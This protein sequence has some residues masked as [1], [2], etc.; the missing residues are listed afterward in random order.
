MQLRVNE[1]FYSVQGEGRFTGT[2][3]V[4]LRLSGCNQKCDFCDTLHESFT[5]MTEEEIV[6]HVCKFAARHIVI[7]G[8]EP[9]LQLTTPFINKLHTVGFFV[10]IETN[11]SIALP[12]DCHIDWITCSPKAAPVCLAYVDELKVVYRGQDVSKWETFPAKEHRLQPMDTQNTN[13][14]QR[15]LQQ[16]MEYILTHPIWRL[17]LQTHKMIGVR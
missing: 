2:P 16:T 8:G 11:G 9:T 17:S 10:Q 13:E 14:N 3:A 5:E 4:F 6:E 15:I 1:I 12:E 7:T